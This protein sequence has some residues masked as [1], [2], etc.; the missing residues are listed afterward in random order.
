MGLAAQQGRKAAR[1][2]IDI[3]IRIENSANVIL[4]FIVC[5]IFY[6][7]LQFFQQEP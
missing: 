7:F 4:V 6:P 1:I 2:I 5:F 3:I